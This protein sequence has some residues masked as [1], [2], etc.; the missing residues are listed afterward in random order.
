MPNK[1][2]VV[3]SAHTA[4]FA[5]GPANPVSSW[6]AR[7]ATPNSARQGP[8]PCRKVSFHAL[9]WEALETPARLIYILS[10]SDLWLCSHARLQQG[11]DL[12]C[13]LSALRSRALEIPWVSVQ[14]AP[15]SSKEQ[16]LG[17]FATCCLQLQLVVH[18]LKAPLLCLLLAPACRGI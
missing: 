5:A 7:N 17:C 3:P 14:S 8:F 2:R 13:H 6:G 10:H 16:F 18:P 11:S 15:A 1:G 12:D 9:G 4:G